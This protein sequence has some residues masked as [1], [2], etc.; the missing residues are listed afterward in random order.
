MANLLNKIGVEITLVTLTLV[1]L[2][3]SGC[4]YNTKPDMVYENGKFYDRRPEVMSS[5]VGGDVD[6]K[7]K[8]TPGNDSCPP[9]GVSL[10]YRVK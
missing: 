10:V 7:K 3:G 6:S 8:T 1:S 5:I 4:A 2:G 9:V